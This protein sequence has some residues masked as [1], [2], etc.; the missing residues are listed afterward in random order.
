MRVVVQRVAE[1][2]VRTGDGVAGAI[3]SGMAILVG[4]A[5]DDDLARV[6]SMAAR[7]VGLRIFADAQGRMNVSLQ[8][9]GGE[10]LVVSQFT[11]CGDASKGRRPS[12]AKAARSDVA[13]PLYEAFVDE[14]GR[15]LGR[16]V[17]TGRFGA[18]MKL[19]LVNDGPVTL[20]IDQ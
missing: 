20:V 10:A 19:S 8:D 3:G 17:Q 5:P 6:S 7:L 16:P 14:L 15:A 11:L 4:F 1:A 13:R 9:S 2:A 18:E 12:F